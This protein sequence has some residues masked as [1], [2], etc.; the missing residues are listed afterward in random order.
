MNRKTGPAFLSGS[1]WTSRIEKRKGIFAVGTSGDP[2]RANPAANGN[3]GRET[4]PGELKSLF[5]TARQVYR[6]KGPGNIGVAEPRLEKKK[7][8]GERPGIILAHGL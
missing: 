1:S 5:L 3:I 6:E 8:Q 2:Q 7:H 4:A